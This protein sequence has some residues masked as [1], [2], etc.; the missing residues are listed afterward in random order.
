M[1][2][3]L[4]AGIGNSFLGDDGFGVEVIA[5]LRRRTLPRCVRI[6]DFGIRGI[7]LAY[8]LDDDL[9]A[10]ILV[11]TVSLGDAPGTI[12]IV[13]HECGSGD[14]LATAPL[15]TGEDGDP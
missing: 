2:G 13:E 9:D 3:V 14:T 5:R 7:D 4:I 15:M 1:S 10:V 11:D 8:A 6:H 12:Y